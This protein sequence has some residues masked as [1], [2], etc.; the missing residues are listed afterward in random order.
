MQSILSSLKNILEEILNSFFLSFLPLRD[1]FA[2]IKCIRQWTGSSEDA[3]YIMQPMI[4]LPYTVKG[5]SRGVVR[6]RNT[7]M[8]R[9]TPI[10]S[11]YKSR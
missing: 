6:V 11:V 4:V 1:E 2:F 3:D 9:V 8:R 5:T 7:D 10:T